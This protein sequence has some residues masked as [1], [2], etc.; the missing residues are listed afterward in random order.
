M[1]WLLALLLALFAA[2]PAAADE[3]RPGY[4]ELTQQD[5]QHW[6][7]VWK[8]PVLGGLATH[9]RPLI[10]PQCRQSVPVAR[11]EGAALIAESTITC[12]TSL[13]GSDIGLA[14]M[15]AAFTD[16]LVRIAPLGRPVQAA[17]LTPGHATVIVASVPDRWDVARSYF[18]LGIQH[19]LTGYDH[20]LF[21][22]ALVLL[23]GKLGIVVRAAT[24]FTVAH[25]LTLVGATLGVIGLA[26]APVEALIALSIVFLAVEVVKQDAAS[27]RLSKRIPW[28]V[29]FGFGLIHGF[30]FAGALREIGLPEGDVPTALLAF[31]LGVEAGQLL[32][33]AVSLL[34]LAAVRR[35]LPLAQRPVKLAASYA[36][37]ITAS[38]WFIQR[39]VG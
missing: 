35:L 9:A 8:A 25:S 23:L 37:G 3:L 13:A 17:R 20:L 32:I 26:Q 14:G 24:A 28:V 29:A 27:P 38:F 30:G 19:I 22:V 12:S 18:V 10:P 34:V 1:K 39:L 33:V 5:A 2:G 31:N 16:A 21:V 6:K 11:L 15:D 7:L 4:L 36:I